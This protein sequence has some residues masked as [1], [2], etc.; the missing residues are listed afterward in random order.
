ML[1]WPHVAS[2]PARDRRILHL[3]SLGWTQSEIGQEVAVSQMHVSLLL[4]RHL[5]TPQEL[6]SAA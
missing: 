1:V 5:E 2:M 3:R 6:V 4:R